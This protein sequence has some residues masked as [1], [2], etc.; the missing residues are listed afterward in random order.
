M[1]FDPDTTKQAQEV[2]FSSKL[3]KRFIL[4]YCLVMPMLLGYLP[5]NTWELY[6]T[7]S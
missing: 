6:L 4:H 7:L 1:N 5:K 2:I 3:K